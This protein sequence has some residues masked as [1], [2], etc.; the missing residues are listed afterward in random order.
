MAQVRQHLSPTANLLRNSRLFSLPN[1][2]PRPPVSES[3]GAGITKASDTATLP[4]PTHQAIA[5]TKSSLARG[6]WGLKRPLPSRS[7]LVQVSDPVLR[8]TQLDT[9][10]HVTD[11]DSA[12]DHVRTRQKW[13]EMGV[14]MMKGMTQM[15]DYDLSGTP[16]AGAFEARDDTTSYDT[17]VGLDEAGLYLKALKTNREKNQEALQKTRQTDGKRPQAD[18][19]QA[20]QAEREAFQSTWKEKWEAKKAEWEA[21]GV[22]AKERPEELKAFRLE[23]REARRAHNNA[24][25][26]KYA[27]PPAPFSPFSPPPVDPIV[28]NTKRWKHEGPWLP[29]L[30]AEG[31][32]DYLTKEIGKRR[33]EFNKYLVEFV[34]NEIYTTRR[35]AASKS[36]ETVPMDIAEAEAWHEQQ[37][38]QWATITSAEVDAGIKALRKETANNPLGSKLVTKLILPFLRLP[39]I[40]FKYKAYAEDASNRDIDQYQFDQ[41]TA[42]LSTH[43][44]AGLGYL[45]TKAYLANHPILGPQNSPSPTPAR[46]IQP[47]TTSTTKE[48]YARLGVGGFVA[49][50]QYRSTDTSSASRANISN[51]RDV[52]TIDIDTPGGK[53]VL[54]QPL[55]GS[56]TNDGR[57]HI[58][59]KR[60]SGPEVQVARASWMINRRL[61]RA[62]KVIR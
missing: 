18:R 60:S 46:V 57:I 17:E 14:P 47:R 31:F 19:R 4:Y 2:L 40:K 23:R 24:L 8:I 52:E 51:A 54:V 3:F 6:D 37:E 21:L 33:D 38:K 53:K 25:S 48:V 13:E 9:I 15:R 61:G 44:S 36:G 59:L 41:E 34:K 55:F 29:G 27:R 22:T 62:W 10:E 26:A 1:P 56:V 49:N 5:T 16:P 39:A 45:R 28:H 50:D 30:G 11:F 43:P 42:P 20:L 35:L 32:T 7:H 12:A 58:K